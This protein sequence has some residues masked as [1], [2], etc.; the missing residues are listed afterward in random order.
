MSDNRIC[1]PHLDEVCANFEF[2]SG[3]GEPNQWG[4]L[5]SGTGNETST[6]VD[7]GYVSLKTPT[8]T[9]RVAR[10]SIEYFA[11]KS[12]KYNKILITAVL[13]VNNTL[14]SGSGVTSRIGIFDDKDDKIESTDVGL[15]FEYTLTD[16]TPV[17][18]VDGNPTSLVHPLK[19]GIRYNSTNNVLGDTIISQPN[20]NA[21]DLMRH[22][23]L[24]YND[25]S[26]ICTYEIK[27]NAIGHVE[28]AIYLDGERILLHKLQD[29]T[30]VLSTLPLYI[31]PL[32]VEIE[33]N[34]SGSTGTT[35]ELRQFNSSILCEKGV[36]SKCTIV[37]TD[38]P[39]N[40]IRHLKPLTTLLY[41]ID[42][43]NY[44]PIFSIRLKS[45]NIRDMIKL[46]E[47]LYLVHKRAPF[48]Y[49]II[50]NGGP[51]TPIWEDP[52]SRS[53][54]E[55]DVVSDSITN[56][57]NCIWEEYVDADCNG[58]V[59]HEIPKIK[60]GMQLIT[61][62]IFGTPDIFTIVVKKMTHKKATVHFGFRWVE[63]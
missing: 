41:T 15:F 51:T 40:E 50:K 35:D 46:Y 11:A 53:R 42:T 13:N 27:Y 59:Q 6:W 37:G 45:D 19:V 23:H 16:G 60:C 52:D 63:S 12:Y 39:A 21:N 9:D 31:A 28:W 20:F 58:G 57:D 34:E 5:L 4:E 2:G 32:R 49:A 25:W 33:N 56:T 48:V 62:N 61:S 44:E 8:N 30:V 17:N 36:V 29:I 47:V 55:Y 1:G 43:V 22:T 3:K 26:Q 7:D 38:V 14:Q 18:D 10:Q 24:Q 54:L